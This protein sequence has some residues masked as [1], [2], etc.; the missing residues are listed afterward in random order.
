MTL[1]ELN[2][3]F[4]KAHM[5]MGVGALIG[6]VVAESQHLRYPLLVGLLAGLLFSMHI[7]RQ[8][9]SVLIEEYKRLK[10]KEDEKNNIS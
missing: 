5:F 9:V 3:E 2:Y 4:F 1:A 6:N 8:C 10:T 7:Y